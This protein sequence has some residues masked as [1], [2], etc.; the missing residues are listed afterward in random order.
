[1]PHDAEAPPPYPLADDA[2]VRGFRLIVAP[3]S[4]RLA[5]PSRGSVGRTTVQHGIAALA[6]VAA[7]LVAVLLRESHALTAM[8][9]LL[10]A[11]MLGAWRGFWP[12]V[13]AALLVLAG[14]TLLVV[15]AGGPHPATALDLAAFMAVTCLV[16]IRCGWQERHAARLLT[17]AL[18]DPLTGLPNRAALLDG[19]DRA[20]NA[21]ATGGPGV[22]LISL[23]IDDTRRSTTGSAAA[24]WCCA[25]WRT[26]GGGAAAGI[27]SPGVMD[28]SRYRSGATLEDAV[29]VATRLLT[30]LASRSGS[31]T[32]RS[33]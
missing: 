32:A 11:V 28:S 27:W 4:A 8:A 13:T 14:L 10:L 33:A 24:G 1:V 12:G 29:A 19:L 31:A 5:P 2:D 15:T 3:L 30:A 25:P 20:C 7:V 23:D 21:A 17:A 18:H 9:A 22:A 6:A 16:L 26:A